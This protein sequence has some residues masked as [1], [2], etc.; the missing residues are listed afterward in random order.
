[1]SATG[2]SFWHPPSCGRYVVVIS[3]RL[4]ALW[5][6]VPA[7]L[8]IDNK[9]REDLIAFQAGGSLLYPFL[10][11]CSGHFSSILELC[12]QQGCSLFRF[13]Q[14]VIDPFGPDSTEEPFLRLDSPQLLPLS[15]TELESSTELES[16]SPEVEPAERPLP[17]LADISVFELF[18]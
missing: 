5:L 4:V 17:D 16:L 9:I 14:K 8:E 12:G 18:R 1:M 2:P 10:S 13:S 3:G 7:F 15:P 11:R 6:E